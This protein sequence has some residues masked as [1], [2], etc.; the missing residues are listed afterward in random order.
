MEVGKGCGKLVDCIF[1]INFR[2]L[3]VWCFLFMVLKE[4]FIGFI[5]YLFIMFEWFGKYLKGV[6]YLVRLLIV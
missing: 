1:L 4:F 2:Y 6:D 5:V 3:N